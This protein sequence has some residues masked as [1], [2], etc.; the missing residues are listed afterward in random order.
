VQGC[1]GVGRFSNG[2]RFARGGLQGLNWNHDIRSDRQVIADVITLLQSRPGVIISS[3][4]LPGGLPKYCAPVA[5]TTF[6]WEFKE[7]RKVAM[8]N[9]YSTQDV[10]V[11]ALITV[12]C[13]TPIS[14]D[15]V[16]AVEETVDHTISVRLLTQGV[17]GGH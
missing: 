7:H 1:T 11:S 4:H 9:R 3:P 5:D 2:S 16:E 12:G 17:V 15:L 8:K 14:P 13:D 6:E 10:V